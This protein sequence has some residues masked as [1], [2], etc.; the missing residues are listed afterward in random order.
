M[1]SYTKR[2]LIYLFA[3]FLHICCH[4]RTFVVMQEMLRFIR[5]GSQKTLNLG[6]RAKNTEFAALVTVTMATAMTMISR[7]DSQEAC[8]LTMTMTMTTLMTMTMIPR[9]LALCRM[10]KQGSTTWAAHFVRFP[11]ILYDDDDDDNNED[12]NDDDDAEENAQDVQAKLQWAT[13]S[14]DFSDN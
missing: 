2:A 3:L 9:K 5:F 14:G 1:S 12:N 8:T 6:L 4:L 13:S 7:G 11:S 10:A